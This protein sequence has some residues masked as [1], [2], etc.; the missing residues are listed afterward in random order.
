MV[1]LNWKTWLNWSDTGQKCTVTC[2]NNFRNHR[3]LKYLQKNHRFLY[4]WSAPGVTHVFKA[5]NNYFSMIKMTIPSIFLP[6]ANQFLLVLT[7]LKISSITA[8]SCQT[9][10]QGIIWNQTENFGY[11]TNHFWSVSLALVCSAYSRTNFVKLF[12]ESFVWKMVCKLKLR[13]NSWHKLR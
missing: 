7:I 4:L 2:P 8:D 10:R 6:P 1:E 12:L 11:R 13:F 5:S 9:Y 3:K